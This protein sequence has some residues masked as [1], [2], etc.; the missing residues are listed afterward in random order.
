MNYAEKLQPFHSKLRSLVR[1]A[2]IFASL[3]VVAAPLP[4]IHLRTQDTAGNV[5]QFITNIMPN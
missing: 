3:G 2:L 1:G 5:T 4:P